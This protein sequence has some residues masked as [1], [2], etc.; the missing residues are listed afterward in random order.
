MS[1][2]F[3][4]TVERRS[5]SVSVFIK[6]AETY[7][8]AIHSVGGIFHRDERWDGFKFLLSHLLAGLGKV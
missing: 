1:V 5:N 8:N 7:T 6:R 4:E 2:L 3:H